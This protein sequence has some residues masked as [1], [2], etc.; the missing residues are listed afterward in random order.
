MTVMMD[1]RIEHGPDAGAAVATRTPVLI[2][3]GGSSLGQ[4]VAL[5]LVRAGA[6]I[7]VYDPG[8][9]PAVL[10][11]LR[12]EAQGASGDVRPIHCPD[13]EDAAALIAAAADQMEGIAALVNLFIPDPRA[14]SGPLAAYPA[15]LLERG[16]AAARVIAGTT[17]HG[18]IVNHCFM[19]SM[20][21]GT[22]LEDSMS[23]LKGA[24]TGVTR[25]LCRKFGRDG[26]RV[27]CVQ[28]GLLDLPEVQ[29]FTS[30][31]LR[32]VKVPIGRWGRA[33]DVAKLVAFLVLRNR[34]MT[35]QVVILDGGLTSG[36][37]GT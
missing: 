21:V 37:T 15:A 10:E 17:S 9:D 28:T 23:A 13:R 22:A 25:A 2:H 7:G 19:P 16:L 31:E 6:T 5:E 33:E 12:D 8:V 14:G 20:Y 32:A 34:Y 18:A 3:G 27:H 29:E 36:Q 11:R 30:P 24:V 35:G 4:A 1:D 26:V